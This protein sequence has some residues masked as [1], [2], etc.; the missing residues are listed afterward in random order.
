MAIAVSVLPTTQNLNSGVSFAIT[1]TVTGSAGTNLG[2]TWSTSDAT[3]ATVTKR[4]S[5]IGDVVG[6]KN[7]AV[8]LTA[9]SVEDGTKTA[10]CAVTVLRVVTVSNPASLTA[11]VLPGDK[12]KIAST[13]LGS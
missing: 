8:T 10:T 6:L 12:L 5:L 4:T 2:V 3:K 9:T 1:A 13:C 11:S 7:G